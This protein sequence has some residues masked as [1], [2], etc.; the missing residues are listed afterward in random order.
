MSSI[1]CI[2]PLAKDLFTSVPLSFLVLA[3]ALGISRGEQ[4]LRI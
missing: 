1:M 2:Y 4:I 3:E